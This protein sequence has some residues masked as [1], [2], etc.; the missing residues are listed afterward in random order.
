VEPSRSTL[1]LNQKSGSHNVW[2]AMQMK[3]TGNQPGFRY[4]VDQAFIRRTQPKNRTKD[5]NQYAAT[6]FNES[7][8]MA[9]S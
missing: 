1:N 5:S 6:H 9:F 3:K 7:I 2:H 8:F 4:Q